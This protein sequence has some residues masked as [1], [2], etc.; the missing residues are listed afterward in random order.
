LMLVCCFCLQTKTKLTVAASASLSLLEIW[1]CWGATAVYI[2]S[3][4]LYTHF[5][6]RGSLRRFYSLESIHTHTHTH[7]P[8]QHIS[9]LTFLFLFWLYFL[10]SCHRHRHIAFSS[11]R[12]LYIYLSRTF[13]LF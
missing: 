5:R 13:P 7:K 2:I 3:V 9:C 8:T 10:F 11:L 6:S 1:I 12:R 4:P